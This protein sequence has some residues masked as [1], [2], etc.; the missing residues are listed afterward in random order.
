MQRVLMGT[1]LIVW[2]WMSFRDGACVLTL[3]RPRKQNLRLQ[4]YGPIRA[5]HCC[6]RGVRQADEV[7]PLLLLSTTPRVHVREEENV[8]SGRRWMIPGCRRS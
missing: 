8:I 7:L 2:K 3:A 4:P 1:Q 5:H 6:G